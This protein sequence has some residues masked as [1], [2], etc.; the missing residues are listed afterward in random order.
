[1]TKKTMG[2][3]SSRSETWASNTDQIME[4]DI[5]AALN[6]ASDQGIQVDEDEELLVRVSKDTIIE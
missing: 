5:K 4:E 3:S 2:G 1:M 6:K